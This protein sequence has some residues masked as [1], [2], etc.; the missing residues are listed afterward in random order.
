MGLVDEADEVVGEVVQQ[1]VRAIAGLAAVEDPRVI[2][3]AAA[4][5][6]L[7]QHL[8]VVLGALA[9]PVDSS[10]LPAAS[11]SAHRSLSSLPIAAT[12]SSII[13]SRTL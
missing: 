9:Q 7:A 2:L 4:E 12:A 1:A 11:S 13:P 6:E 5:P 10:S 8:H 3:D